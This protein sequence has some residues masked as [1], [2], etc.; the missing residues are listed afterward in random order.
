[1]AATAAA[2]LLSACGGPSQ[3][4]APPTNGASAAVN[5]VT[6]DAG[7]AT[8]PAL[9][10]PLNPA[11]DNRPDGVKLPEFLDRM[12]A[13]QTRLAA[14]DANFLRGLRAGLQSGSEPGPTIALAAYRTELGA[15]LAA[16][17]QAPLLAGCFAK[18]SVADGKVTLD[19]AAML[20][21][22]QTKLAAATATD[23]PLT[24][25]DFGPLATDIA[26]TGAG[27]TV[28]ADIAAA[29]TAASGCSDAPKPRVEHTSGPSPWSEAARPAVVSP[30]PSPPVAPA[31]APGNPNL[32]ERFRRVFH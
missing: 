4:Q 26:S 29:R 22:R 19:A 30:P 9:P 12:A 23:D 18:A 31:P 14:A 8:A 3:P 24:L 21:D 5:A 2:V 27:E 28:T 7:A 11:T 10:P 17:P 6:L 32:F 15:E 1:M 16:L 20:T 25:A 13:Q